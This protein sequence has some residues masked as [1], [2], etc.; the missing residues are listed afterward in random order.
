MP[1]N[2]EEVI[3]LPLSKAAFHVV[4]FAVTGELNAFQGNIGIAIQ[5]K[6]L[7]SNYLDEMQ[8]PEVQE[9]ADNLARLHAATCSEKGNHEQP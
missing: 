8:A 9:L 6:M 2:L 3:Q 1:Q 7:L 4:L 5:C